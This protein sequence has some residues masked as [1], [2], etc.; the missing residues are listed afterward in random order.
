[1]SARQIIDQP[2]DPQQIPQGMTRVI[3]TRWN[4]VFTLEAVT[5]VTYEEL[6]EL[7]DGAIKAALPELRSSLR[8]EWFKE[9]RKCNL[10][11]EASFVRAADEARKNK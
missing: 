7:V 6:C 1:M 2:S 9:L 5:P 8:K 10:T 4:N 3:E 11:D